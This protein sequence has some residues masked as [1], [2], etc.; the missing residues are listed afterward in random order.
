MVVTLLLAV[1]A[2]VGLWLVTGGRALPV[3]A[4]RVV[5]AGAAVVTLVL[6]VATALTSSEVDKP[7]VPELGLRLAFGV[8]GIAVPLV[9]LTALVG[10]L[11]AA[12]AWVDVPEGGTPATFLGCLLLVEAGAL[13]TFTARDAVLFFLAFELVLVPMW[14]LIGRYGDRHDPR[15]RADAKPNRCKVR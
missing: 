1:P 3:G 15:A 5:T 10:V 4:A 11:V 9:L 13:A 7:W 2:P 8:D 14:L 12:H 6:A